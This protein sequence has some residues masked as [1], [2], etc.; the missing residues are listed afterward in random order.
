M[1]ENNEV[2]GKGFAYDISYPEG[3]GGD[4]VMAIVIAPGSLTISFNRYELGILIS[5]LNHAF[6]IAH[7]NP[8][9]AEIAEW[10]THVL[11]HEEPI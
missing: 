10:A 5:R 2:A 6:E 4:V 7:G 3:T 9:P 1:N 11:E 8:T